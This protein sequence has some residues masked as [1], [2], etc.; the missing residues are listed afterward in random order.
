MY[1]WFSPLTKLR[2]SPF[3]TPFENQI[4]LILI[5]ALLICN[6]ARGLA[7]R[8]AGGLALTA[9]TVL[10]GLCNIFSFDSIDSLHFY[11]PPIIID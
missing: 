1:H 10:Y 9:A 5:L 6:A 4:L 11:N 3:A 8:L 7:S 2:A